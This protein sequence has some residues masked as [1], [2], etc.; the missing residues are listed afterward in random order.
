MIVA[1]PGYLHV[2]FGGLLS[3]LYCLGFPVCISLF[4]LQGLCFCLLPFISILVYLSA[5]FRCVR[6]KVD[7]NLD[8][9]S[10]RLSD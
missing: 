3:K 7:I 4:L 9:L 6:C 10:G 8:K 2:Y 1:S 5:N